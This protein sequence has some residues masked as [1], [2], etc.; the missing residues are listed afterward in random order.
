MSP[1]DESTSR[2]DDILKL[3]RGTKPTSYR[4]Y[5]AGE[6]V[7]TAIES[8]SQHMSTIVQLGNQYFRKRTQGNNG[9]QEQPSPAATRTR[10]GTYDSQRQS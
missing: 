1:H 5:D 3:S 9:L 4:P 6:I 10:S 2:A 8:E 7:K